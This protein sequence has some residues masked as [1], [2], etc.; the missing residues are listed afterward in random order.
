MPSSAFCSPEKAFRNIPLSLLFIVM[1]LDVDLF[2]LLCWLLCLLFQSGD[3]WVPTAMEAQGL[4]GKGTK[5]WV[6]RN[7]LPDSPTPL[8]ILPD[9]DVPD[10]VPNTTQKVSKATLLSVLS[11]LWM[12]SRRLP[13]PLPPLPQ[14]CTLPNHMPRIGYL[15]RWDLE[16]I[17]G[18]K[19]GPK[20]FK[21][22]FWF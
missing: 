16:C 2:P 12:S 8:G 1:C 6:N 5:N 22:R 11:A 20:W 15:W 10:R 3:F 13:D 18:C 17:E 19:L 7:T 9:T 4:P 14:A 21:T